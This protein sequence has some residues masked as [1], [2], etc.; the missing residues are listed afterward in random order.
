MGIANLLLTIGFRNMTSEETD[1]EGRILITVGL[2][3]F[4]AFYG[5][6]LGPIVWLY[7]PEI[8]QDRVVPISTAVNWLFASVVIILVPILVG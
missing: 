3:V 8:V 6:S 4:M 7:I 5:L 2:F 1:E